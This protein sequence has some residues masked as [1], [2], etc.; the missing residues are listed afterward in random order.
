MCKS[1]TRFMREWG[2]VVA[3]LQ[4][5]LVTK[6]SISLLNGVDIWFR[7]TVLSQNFLSSL[8]SC[9][10]FPLSSLFVFSRYSFSLIMSSFLSNSAISMGDSDSGVRL[11]NPWWTGRSSLLVVPHQRILAE[12]PLTASPPLRRGWGWSIIIF[13]YFLILFV[14]ILITD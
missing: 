7:I 12:V 3:P 5:P 14:T 2:C 10:Q 11:S 1:T 4:L 8:L 13:S 6:E 9:L